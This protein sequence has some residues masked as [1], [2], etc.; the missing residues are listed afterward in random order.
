MIVPVV[1]HNGELELTT[2]ALLDDGA[3]TTIVS[4]KLAEELTLTCRPKMAT[5]HTVEGS[6]Y[7]ERDMVDFSV[8]NLD[9]DLRVEVREALVSDSLTTKGDIPPKN[10]EIAHLSYMKGVVFRELETED[11]DLIL[12]VEY[13]YYWR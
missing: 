12:S 1:V 2:Y 6:S 9:S 3:D 13:S 10:A 11:I 7:K 5:L 4:N 8:S